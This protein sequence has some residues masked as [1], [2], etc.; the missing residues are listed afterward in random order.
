MASALQDIGAGDCLA[1]LSAA[2]ASWLGQRCGL[3][4]MRLPVSRH[5]HLPQLSQHS[6]T[7][8]TGA[9]TPPADWSGGRCPR[10]PA[11][12][13]GR[14]AAWPPPPRPAVAWRPAPRGAPQSR[15]PCA[16]S[17]ARR[18]RPRRSARRWGGRRRRRLCRRPGARPAPPA[19][20]G[21]T[22]A[23]RR[24][25]IAG[26]RGERAVHTPMVSALK[27]IQPHCVCMW[28][29]W[30]WRACV[31][32][33]TRARLQLGHVTGLRRA[34][35]T[36]GAAALLPCLSYRPRVPVSP[37]APT[38]AAD[39][40]AAAVR[41]GVQRRQRRAGLGGRHRGAEAPVGQHGAPVRARGHQHVAPRAQ[42]AHRR[43]RRA[44]RGRRR[45]RPGARGCA[46][47]ESRRPQHLFDC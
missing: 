33:C 14:C 43:A 17:A 10:A 23:P 35:P 21:H 22:A 5:Q 32:K 24:L 39:R 4:R 28:V 11:P 42:E 3:A 31:R 26:R 44:R 2:S 9:D 18:W 29:C 41:A 13:A 30:V 20:A 27:G 7:D 25:R 8:T 45:L 47:V 12:A 34:R 36:T 46:A 38:G 40:Q 1:C 15:R 37:G 6:G 16:A 19:F